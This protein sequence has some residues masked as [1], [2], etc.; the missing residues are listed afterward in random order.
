MKQQAAAPGL[1]AA[2]YARKST[3]QEDARS[4]TRQ[5]EQ[6]TAYARERGWIVAPDHIFVDDGRSGALDETKRAGLAACLRAMEAKPRPFDCPIGAAANPPAREPVTRGAVVG[7]TP[8]A[9]LKPTIHP[10]RWHR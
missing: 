5:V 4:V 8:H 7:Q 9:K 2:I 10:D 1:R 3:A 6:A